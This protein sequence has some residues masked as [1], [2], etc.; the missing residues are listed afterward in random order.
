MNLMLVISPY[1]AVL[2]LFKKYVMLLQKEEPLI[3]KVYN[4]LIS[5]ICF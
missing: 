5:S 2:P 3:H 1:K 4:K